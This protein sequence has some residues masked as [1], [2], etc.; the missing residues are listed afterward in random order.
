MRVLEHPPVTAGRKPDPSDIRDNGSA[1]T[2][3]K[4]GRTRRKALWAAALLAN[5]VIVLVLV[6]WLSASLGRFYG[7]GFADDY[8]ALALNLAEGN[9]YRLHADTAPTMMREPGYPLFLAGVFRVFGYNI[10]GARFANV[11]LAI[12]ISLMIAKLARAL[13]DNPTVSIVAVLLFLFHPGT[14]IAELR[15]SVE[16]FFICGLLAFMLVLHWA[17]RTKKRSAFLAAGCVLGAV[18]LT[19]STPM[20]FPL[21]LLGYLVIVSKGNGERIT[22]LLNI[23]ILVVG[24]AMVMSPWVI[25]NWRLTGQFVPTA[26]V[27]GV[28][29]HAGQYICSHLEFDSNFLDLD[30]A[31]ARERDLLARQLGHPYRAGYYQYFYAPENELEFNQLLLSRVKTNYRENPLL[32]AKCPAVN[33]FNFW[34]AGKTRRVTMVNVLFQLPFMIVAASGAWLMWRRGE[35]RRMAIVLLF[36]GYLFALHVPIHAQARYSVPLVPFLSIFAGVAV[37]SSLRRVLRVETRK[38]G[39][40][41][42]VATR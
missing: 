41:P 9:G 39:P 42:V 1:D 4:R 40:G 8:D 38:T 31:G 34:F 33:V 29:A 11:L 7:I 28:A 18:V 19:R 35:T 32:L 3:E 30:R 5:A 37:V 13:F 26:S 27:Q 6:P 24:M 15:G 2:A 20:I 21:F 22:A 36:I 17:I 10:E 14:L 23:A 12:A 16:M 25:R